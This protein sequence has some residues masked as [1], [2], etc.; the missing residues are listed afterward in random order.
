MKGMQTMSPSKNKLI[1]NNS[2]TTYVLLLESAAI[3]M[4]LECI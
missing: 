4:Y 3:G 2:F 1:L